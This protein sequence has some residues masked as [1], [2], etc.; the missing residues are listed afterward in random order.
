M[1]ARR[2]IAKGMTVYT[3]DGKAMGKVVSVDDLGLFVEKGLFFP[4]E[5]GIRFDDV[6]DV[7]ADGVHLRL[8]Q[9][10]VEGGTPLKH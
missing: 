2:G 6:E 4:K 9:Q 10:A 8:S 1:D 7:R 5:F 3:Q